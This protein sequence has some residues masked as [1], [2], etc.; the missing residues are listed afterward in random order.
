MPVAIPPFMDN[1]HPLAVLLALIVGGL[2]GIWASALARRYG[3]WLEAG[4]EPDMAC[5][6]R[7]L[8]LCKPASAGSPR[9][10][11]AMAPDAQGMA[12]FSVHAQAGQNAS[13]VFASGF[14]RPAWLRT[15]TGIALLLLAASTVWFCMRH[16][17]SAYFVALSAAS[18]LLLC[19][20]LIDWRTGLLPDA[21]DLPLLV[22][23]LLTA[24]WLPDGPSL[25]SAAAG[26]A[27]GFGVLW[28]IARVFYLVRGIEGMGRGDFKLAAALGAWCGIQDLPT[29]LLIASFAGV[30]FGMAQQR[31][32]RPA[33]AYPFGPFLAGAGLAVLLLT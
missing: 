20:A 24:W 23:G 28:L 32:L 11:D 30:V 14:S 25:P 1:V 12:A 3:E 21:L 18:F 17:V 16:G 29:V 6:L 27:F 19:L 22:L 7:A 10:P 33:G 4:A 13:P 9:V 31:S 26:A 5:L 8:A 15:D 2:L